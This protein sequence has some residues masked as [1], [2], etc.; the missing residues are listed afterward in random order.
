MFW[1]QNLNISLGSLT[2]YDFYFLWH[3]M[4]ILTH[5]EIVYI[6]KLGVYLC[7]AVGMLYLK[8]HPH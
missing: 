8:I 1:E 4:A 7:S 6:A 3:N 2:P 5:R